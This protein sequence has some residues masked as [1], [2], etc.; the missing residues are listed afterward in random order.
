MNSLTTPFITY[1][2]HK[3]SNQNGKSLRKGQIKP[4][5]YFDRNNVIIN[6]I[7]VVILQVLIVK[8][9]EETATAKPVVIGVR[10]T[11]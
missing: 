3:R 7:F 6:Y 9:I 11:T 4:F 8:K 1:I 5:A 2:I 10:S